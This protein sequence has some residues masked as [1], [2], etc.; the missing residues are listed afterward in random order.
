MISL[1]KYHL[2]KS[3]FLTYTILTY[4][5]SDGKKVEVKVKTKPEVIVKRF[6]G[7]KEI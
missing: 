1:G 2:K 3:P 5:S 7:Q 6:R 4:V